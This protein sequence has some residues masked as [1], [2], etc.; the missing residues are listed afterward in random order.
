[1]TL[2]KILPLIAQAETKKY[3]TDTFFKKNNLFDIKNKNA[4]QNKSKSHALS[5]AFRQRKAET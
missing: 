4:R 2:L 1:V 5:R 3:Q